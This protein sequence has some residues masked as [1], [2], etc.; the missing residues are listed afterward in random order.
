MSLSIDDDWLK[1]TEDQRDAGPSSSVTGGKKAFPRLQHIIYSY[2]QKNQTVSELQF[3]KNTSLLTNNS[4]T[5]AIIRILKEY[6]SM[7]Y[8]KILF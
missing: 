6:L 2:S 5:F 1:P 7:T 3:V 8:R 4:K